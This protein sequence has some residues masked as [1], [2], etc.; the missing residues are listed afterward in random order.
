MDK[1]L[2]QAH[3]SLES[4]GYYLHMATLLYI[5]GSE[6]REKIHTKIIV[7]LKKES[8]CRYIKHKPNGTL[9]KSTKNDK[10]RKSWTM[11]KY[12]ILIYL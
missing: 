4:I 10:Y 2:E 7:I 8:S 11:K 6:K 5:K 3:D 12:S 1:V 9:S